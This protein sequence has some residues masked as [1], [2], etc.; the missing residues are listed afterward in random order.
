MIQSISRG[1][2]VVVGADL[3]GHVGEGN[4]GDEEVTGESV[5]KQHCM[6]VCK[7]IM[8]MRKRKRVKTEPKIKW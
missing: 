2:T 4:R 7:I 1:E 6:V 5:A 3:N 8:K